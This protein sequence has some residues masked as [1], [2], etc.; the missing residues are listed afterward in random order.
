MTNQQIAQLARDRGYRADHEYGGIVV[1][2]IN[3]KPSMMEIGRELN[4]SCGLLHN[5][6]AGIVIYGSDS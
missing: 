5:H 6:R 1:W 2:L 4:I 3:R